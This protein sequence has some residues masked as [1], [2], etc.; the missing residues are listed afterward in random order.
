M[1]KYLSLF[2]V[3][4][5]L[6]ALSV[7]AAVPAGYGLA[8]SDEFNGTAIDTNNWGFDVGPGVPDGWGNAEQEYYTKG[9][10]FTI[11]NGSGV[12]WAKRETM[13]NKNY[14]SCRIK[15]KG[16]KEF[17]Y[18][19]LEV[20]IKAAKGNGLWPAFWT[21]G[22]DID[23][24]T[25]P[26]C[27]ELE[28][29]EQRTGTTNYSGTI[30][31]NCF[32]QTCHYSSTYGAVAPVYNTHQTNFTACLCNDYHLY[33]ILWDSLS[34][35]YYFDG[36]QVW[37]YTNINLAS[38]KKSFH[39]PHFFIANIAVGGN[40]QGNNIDNSIFPQ[41]M[42][43]DYIRVYQKGVV[44]PVI[45]GAKSRASLTFAHIADPSRA[46]LAVFD[47][48]GRLVA[49]YTNRVRALKA[50]DAVMKAIPSGMSAGAH[51]ISFSDGSNNAS[52]QRLVTAR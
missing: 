34:F 13:G 4:I 46:R 32:V 12:L 16:K 3:I 21:L 27:G 50:G 48:S 17:K 11:E 30:G 35:T 8:W 40:Y 37:Q 49:D 7:T 24:S 42:Y 33:A 36:N 20:R 38:N 52:V 1:K 29:Y 18:G 6:S 10:N 2:A 43:I 39:Q 47:V 28:L 44:T 14:T 15:T 22:S 31:D 26:S 51:I 23:V 45:N 41:K 25:W 9:S 5:G 19:Y